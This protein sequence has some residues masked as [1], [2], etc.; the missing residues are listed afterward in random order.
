MHQQGKKNKSLGVS[1]CTMISL[2]HSGW[3]CGEAFTCVKS[4][5]V[6]SVCAH[7]HFYFLHVSTH[8]VQSTL[9]YACAP[10][11]AECPTLCANASLWLQ[12][13]NSGSWHSWVELLLFMVGIGTDRW[14]LLILRSCKK[15]PAVLDAFMFV[16]TL[17]PPCP[18]LYHPWLLLLRSCPCSCRLCP[19]HLWASLCIIISVSLSTFPHVSG[20]LRELYPSLCLPY[21]SSPPNMSKALKL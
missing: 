17:H 13:N 2:P 21:A 9:A 1:D 10:Y 12:I 16:S 20:S 8:V 3:I 7:T 4:L 6:C 18:L 11:S 15:K 19:L 14:L 5:V